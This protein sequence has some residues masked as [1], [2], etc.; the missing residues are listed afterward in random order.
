MKNTIIAKS[1]D[2]GDEVRQFIIEHVEE[3]P[4][5]IV[6]QASHAFGISRQAVS[7]HM[8]R[9]VEEGVL[10]AEGSTRNRRY[11]LRA[12]VK[13]DLT[14]FLEGLQE[15]VVW[16]K[17]I[18]PLLAD[19]PGNVKEIWNYGVT[20]ML[21]NAVDHS[22]GSVV[23]VRVTVT[24]AASQIV[25]ADN[26]EGIFQKISR[27]FGL[28]DACHAIL[29]LAKGKFTTDPE[30]HTGQGIFFSSRMFDHFTIV[31]GRTAFLRNSVKNLDFIQDIP[32]SAEGTTVIMKLRNHATHT[33]KEIFDAF[34]SGDDYGFTKTIVPVRLAQYGEESL[35]SRSQAK[36]L[37]ARFDRFRVVVLDFKGVESIGQAFTDEVFRVFVKDHPQTSVLAVNTAVEVQQMIERARGELSGA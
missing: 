19:L 11:A 5:D 1:R 21:N 29:E 9:L 27:E 13:K 17:D 2:R 12:R 8:R 36:R 14:Y 3:H 23:V 22:S 32:E 25:I 6:T 20:E 18:A 4:M 31:S 28:D 7:K 35:V 16:R 37:L 30:R 33:S 10:T 34:T 24:A 26:G 15:D